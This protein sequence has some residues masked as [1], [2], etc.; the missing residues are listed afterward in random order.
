MKAT[1]VMIA[2]AAACQIGPALVYAGIS[3]SKTEINLG[4]FPVDQYSTSVMNNGIFPNCPSNISVRDCIKR[5]FNNNPSFGTVYPGNYVSQ[6]VTGVRFQ[7][8]LGGGGGNPGGTSTPFD[9]TG[10]VLSAWVTNLD[11]FFY[12]LKQCGIQRVTPTPVVVEHWSGAGSLA[13][14]E[15]TLTSCG[16][17]KK[18]FFLKWLPFGLVEVDLGGGEKDYWPDGQSNN[19]AYNCAAT[20]PIFWG[21]SKLFT[22]ID[23]I[24][25]KAQL[26][27]L[28]VDE[29][30]LQNEVNIL[31]FDVMAR[32]IYDNNTSTK[33]LES[34]GQKMAAHGFSSRRATVSVGVHRPSVNGFHCGSV[35]GDSAMI[36]RTSEL[37]AT[38]G[39]AK[40]GMPP[41]VVPTN[42]L[43]CDN[44]ETYCG[45]RTSPGW[46]A[47]ATAGMISIA[48]TQAAPTVT[49]MHSTLCVLNEL[50][51][52]NWGLPC[53][54]T[55]KTLYDDVYQYLTY[56]GLL[57]NLV[58]FGETTPTQVISGL[59]CDTIPW[60]KVAARAQDNVNG[61]KDLTSPPERL[62]H[63]NYARAGSV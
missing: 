27:A 51:D 30:D 40:F 18:L 28:A 19:Q 60:D 4:S 33:V 61:Y 34:I 48:F 16:T 9:S 37:L 1:V 8:A 29:F 15:S 46:P 10:N 26:R 50:G 57:S 52:C 11:N 13:K 43:L 59:T 20:N 58:M 3:P 31:D 47:C 49:D 63:L 32:L 53:K 41:Y 17:S 2:L 44:S 36:F 35:Y 12:D 39:G 7:F 38:T 62:Y 5:W 6:G 56:R 14:Q 23:Q 24:L 45:P 42:Q 25:A 21:W 22:L 55:A 54:A